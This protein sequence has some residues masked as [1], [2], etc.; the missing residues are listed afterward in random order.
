MNMKIQLFFTILVIIAVSGLLL[1]G[2]EGGLYEIGF[3]LVATGCV[4]WIWSRSYLDWWDLGQV[5]SDGGPLHAHRG[6]LQLYRYPAY[7]GIS[8]IVLGLCLGYLSLVGFL[9]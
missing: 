5:H 3:I 2:L 4:V 6:A 8:M 7:F 1:H 9:D